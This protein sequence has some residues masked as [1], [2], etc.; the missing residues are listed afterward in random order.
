MIK[1][2]NLLNINNIKQYSRNNGRN[3]ISNFTLDSLIIIAFNLNQLW[4]MNEDYILYL[5]GFYNFSYYF[6]LYFNIWR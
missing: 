1:Y 2:I 3:K 6:K 5:I 4:A